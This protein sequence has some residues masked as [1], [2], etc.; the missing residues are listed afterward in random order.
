M[1]AVPEQLS[2]ALAAGLS[3]FATSATCRAR[4]RRAYAEH[5][6]RQPADRQPLPPQQCACGVRSLTGGV[7]ERR[8]DQH[9]VIAGKLDVCREVRRRLA[10]V[11][12]PARQ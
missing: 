11:R 10:A 1:I 12:Q 5:R 8:V 2:E 4:G 9:L 3:L 6:Q 7:V